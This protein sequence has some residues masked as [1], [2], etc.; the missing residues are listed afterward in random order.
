MNGILA[1]SRT[2]GD[3]YLHPFVNAEPYVAELDIAPEDEFVVLGC[4]GMLA[5]YIYMCVRVMDRLSNCLCLMVCA[6][7]HVFIAW[8]CVIC[9]TYI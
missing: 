8:F 3:K 4:D 7:G 2:L 5:I 1:V 6:C 9:L